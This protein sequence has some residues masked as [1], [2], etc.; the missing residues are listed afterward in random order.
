MAAWKTEPTS[1]FLQGCSPASG[2]SRGRLPGL[3]SHLGMCDL[4]GRGDGRSEI[5]LS[6]DPTGM[7]L[8]FQKLFSVF[9]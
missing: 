1:P 5:V 9:I 8:T 6:P 4:R 3:L 7:L 2:G